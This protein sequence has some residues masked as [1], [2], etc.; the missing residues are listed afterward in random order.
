M[1][2]GDNSTS[3]MRAA[4]LNGG[5]RL[6]AGCW[7]QLTDTSLNIPTQLTRI[8]SFVSDSGDYSCNLET[9]PDISTGG[10]IKGTLKNTGSGATINYIAVGW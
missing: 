6:E 2:F 4:S 8:V 1:G 7:T 10:N 3:F 5:L 9:I